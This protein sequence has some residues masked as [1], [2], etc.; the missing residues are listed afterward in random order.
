[1]S[2]KEDLYKRCEMMQKRQTAYKVKIKDLLDGIYVKEAGEWTPNYIEINEKKVSR[3]NIIGAVVLK[4]DAQGANHSNIILDDGSGKISVRGFDKDDFFRNVDV[5]DVVLL[6]GRPR[7][8]GSEKYVVPEI[9]KRIEN[10]RWIDV[11]KLELK[12]NQNNK[13]NKNEVNGAAKAVEIE[14]IE[15]SPGIKIVQLVKSLDPG[16]GAD[17]NNIISKSERKDAEKIIQNLL[18]EG[19]IFEVRSGKLKVL[20]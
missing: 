12:L 4:Q 15:E 17:I 6:V 18:E 19:E 13:E 3:A 9:L 7:Q 8:F 11:R 20:E 14:S 2:Q 1:L 5:G 10:K 16:D